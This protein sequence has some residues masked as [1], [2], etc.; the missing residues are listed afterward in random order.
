MLKKYFLLIS[1]LVT[2]FSFGQN[3]A[4]IE[5]TFNVNNISN[6]SGG[7]LFGFDKCFPMNDG[8]TMV[9]KNCIGCRMN[10]EP[11]GAYEVL[12]SNGLLDPLYNSFGNDFISSVLDTYVYPDGKQ[13]IA[14]AFTQYNGTAVTGIVRLNTDGTIDNSFTT[15]LDS[16]VYKILVQPDGKI[17][18]AGS[19]TAYG[20][21]TYNRIMR[22]NSDGSVDP[23]FS[24]G[25][26]FDNTVNTMLIQ[27]DGKIVVA[28]NFTS[29]NG[30]ASNRI[31][32]LNADGSY[33]SS[34]A[35]GTGFNAIVSTLSL[36]QDNK[37]FVGGNFT[38]YN[39]VTNNRIIK[40]NL[41]G[42]PDTSFVI[43]TG[44]NAYVNKILSLPDGNIAVMGSFSLYKSSYQY[45]SIK[46]NPLGG[47]ITN[48]VFSVKEFKDAFVQNDGKIIVVGNFSSIG[49]TVIN[50]IARLNSDESVDAT[51]ARGVG[52]NNIVYKVKQLT[53]G[54]IVV[55]GD[56]TL[57]N[58]NP[59]RFLARLNEDGS[60]DS[61]FNNGGSGFNASISKFEI[62]PDGKI[63]AVGYFTSY[64]GVAANGIIRLNADGS[65]DPT[66]ITGTGFDNITTDVVVQS[67]G[68]IIVAG[69]FQYYNSQFV[70]K[71]VRLN[72]N[73]SFD[74]GYQ[75]VSDEITTIA[76]QNDGKLLIAMRTTSLGSCFLRRYNLNGSSDST[77]NY[78]LNDGAN[79][80]GGIMA[81]APQPD[82]KIIVGGGFFTK[83]NNLLRLTSTGIKDT[84]FITGTGFNGTVRSLLIQPDNKI[85][86]GGSFNTYNGIT[87]WHSIRLNINGSYDNYFNT[88]LGFT[89]TICC[90]NL[91]SDG[92]IL[93]AGAM[94]NYGTYTVGSLTRL[95]GGG[96][97]N[98]S[99]QNKLD[100]N[101]NGCDV[102]DYQFPNLKMNFNDGSS[103][104]DFFVNNTGDYSFLLGQGSYT[105]TPIV[106]SNFTISPTSVSA[107]FPSQ[108]TSLVQNYCITPVNG[109]YADLDVQIIPLNNARPGFDSKYKIVYKN[110]GVVTQSG[111]VNLVFDDQVM[112]MIQTTPVVDN[113]SVNNL[114]WNFSN[115]SPQESR[116]ILVDF[117][118]NT[119]TETPSLNSGDVLHFNVAFSGELM[120]FTPSDNTF[121]LNQKVI[122]SYDPN[123]K[124]CLQ[125]D[126]VG[127]EK[128]GDY[129]HYLIRFENNGTANAEF[130][131][132]EDLID[133]TKFE[134]STLEP[135]SG[136]HNFITKISNGNKVEFFFNNIN[137]PFDDANNDGYV[138]Y[139]IKLKPS[140]VNGDSFSNTANIYF[141]FNSAIVTNTA[142]TTITTL[143]NEENIVE[144]GFYLYPN[145]TM[146]F[147][148]I[149]NKSGLEIK[150]ISVYNTIGQL[151]MEVPNAKSESRVNVQRLTAGHYFV[152]LETDK[153][154]TTVKFIKQ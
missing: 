101:L 7:I 16:S 28:G 107:T 73:G 38:T 65:I 69:L 79:T 72:A 104:Y 151:I 106:N 37:I 62:Q 70:N 84:S 10:G 105:I 97:Y 88:G 114:T 14:G 34:L 130:I 9:Y 121:A 46:L 24:I 8:K 17:I 66:F 85:L 18:I 89:G 120:D 138:M 99:G 41:D 115:L 31:I 137:L 35:V 100:A 148:T 143:S 135:L 93:V 80:Y 118:L 109:S 58:N 94:V 12:N 117:N 50:S 139:K 81:L 95:I 133:T 124:T 27:N 141:D 136:S 32:R 126:F 26:G 6:V 33:D 44:F 40:L 36:S 23:S 53:D 4:M 153:G 150:G 103:N 13:L 43:G 131:R 48:S 20:L 52:F 92:K 108:Y 132:I 21:T 102:A 129:V 96:F 82:G 59:L 83:T 112:D 116:S 71:A 22:L 1:V 11:I 149:N 54:K 49:T 42:T 51:F 68:K 19:F 140:L 134:I 63:I 61:S 45:N 47:K 25:T 98:L 142:I 86:V 154:I 122:N 5:N 67:D 127:T 64:N 2:I 152:K 60:I 111:T 75:S 123:D 29:Y 146:D 57:Y 87:S 77:F 125:G 110:K 119:P 3:P 145:P 90:F 147:L 76:L 56:F 30:S 91:Q 74:L 144:N 128:I 15:L 78:Y 39:S 55:G 113:Q